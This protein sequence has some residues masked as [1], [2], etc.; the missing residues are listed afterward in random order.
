MKAGM[1]AVFDGQT[2]ADNWTVAAIPGGPGDPEIV[3]TTTPPV[4]GFAK[5][6]GRARHVVPAD[7][8]VAVYIKVAGGWWTKP[9]HATPETAI[10]IDG[11]WTCDITTGGN[12]ETAT[13]VA[14]FL[15]PA[16]YAPPAAQGEATLPPALA[17][18][19]VDSVQVSR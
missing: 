14:A 13:Q 8:N 11:R 16:T 15:I 7:H 19:A 2:V 9:T 6:Q 10:R 17:S 5:L 18:H 4:G 12:D 3:F 1:R